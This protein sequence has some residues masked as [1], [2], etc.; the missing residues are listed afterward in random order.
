MKRRILIVDDHKIVRDGLK[1]LLRSEPDFDVVGEADNGK[2]ALFATS[3]L[4][5][6]IILMDLSMPNTNGTEAIRNIKRR[7][8]S[9][10]IIALTVHKAEEYIHAA[11]K[12]GASGYLLKDDSHAELMTALRSAIHGKT[13]LTPSICGSVVTGY[14]GRSE[15]GRLTSS[16]ETLTHREREVIKLVA[17]GYRNKEIAEYLSLSMKTVEKHR[18][19][20]MKKLGLHS[21]SALTAYAIENL[22]PIH[23]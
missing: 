17:E 18:S 13:Y 19:N 2:D 11:L 9:I 1:S 12:A 16:W 4:K 20:L 8:P 15:K 7:F 10:I 6:D 14:L 22:T 21:A 23:I 5:P 3:T